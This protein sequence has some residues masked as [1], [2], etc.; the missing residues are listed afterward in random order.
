MTQFYPDLEHFLSYISVL[1]SLKFMGDDSLNENEFLLD[2]T[3]PQSYF[4]GNSVYLKFN[5]LELGQKPMATFRPFFHSLF[6]VLYTFVENNAH[7]HNTNLSPSLRYKDPLFV[8]KLSDAWRD[9]SP[10]EAGIRVPKKPDMDFTTKFIKKTVQRI[11][12]FYS[13]IDEIEFGSQPYRSIH[14][15]AFRVGTGIPVEEVSF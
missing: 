7:T 2:Q 11:Q 12:S 9:L 10:Y 15:A 4:L 14:V 8:L 5:P 1:R 3:I 13:R 6:D